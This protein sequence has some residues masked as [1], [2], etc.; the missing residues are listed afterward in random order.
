MTDESTGAQPTSPHP[1]PVVGISCS[2]GGIRAASYALGGLQVLDDH[3]LLR[4]PNRARYLSAVSGGSYLVGGMTSIQRSRERLEHTGRPEDAAAALVAPYAPGS[5][6]VRR[7]RNRLGYLTHG[8][9]GLRPELWR[10]VFG[11]LINVV[12]LVTAVATLARPIGWLA[13]Y[14]FPQLRWACVNPTVAGDGQ[15][16]CSSTAVPTPGWTVWGAIALVGIAVAIGGWAALRR[17][18]GGPKP[19]Q[20]STLFLL[21]ALGWTAIVIAGPQILG[22]LHRTKVHELA[23]HDVAPAGAHA[24]WFP[25]GGV[26]ALLGALAATVAPVWRT[27]HPKR[28]TLSGDATSGPGAVARFFTRHRATLLN[29][30]AVLVGPVLVISLFVVFAARGAST[31]PFADGGGTGFEL[32]RWGWPLALLAVIAAFGDVNG[33]ALHSLYAE[34]LGDAFGTERVTAPEPRTPPTVPFSPPT[35][36]APASPDAVGEADVHVRARPLPLD[37][38]QPECFPEVLICGTANLSTYGVTPTDQKAASFLLSSA[39]VGGAATG[40]IDT[41]RYNAE[42]FPKAGKLSLIDAVSI[43]GAAVAPAMGKMTRGPLRFLL[44]LA[45]IRLGV[46]VPNPTKVQERVNYRWPYSRPGL[47][48]LA[49]EMV[50]SSP[51]DRRY[52]YV[53]D[54]GHF[55]NLGLVELL[56][57]RCDWIFTIDASGD[58]IDTFGTLGDALSIAEAE[59]GVTVDIDPAG[60]MA[61][62]P[63]EP[64]L[65]TAPCSRGVI[66]YPARPAGPDSPGE[67][68]KEA[69]LVVV[70]AGVPRDAPWPI[71]A[72]HRRF[73]RFPTDPTTDQLFPAPRFDAY[74]SLGRFAMRTA[75]KHWGPDLEVLQGPG[76]G[77]PTPLP[78]AS[79]RRAPPV[80]PPV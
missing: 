22:W 12:A 19:W 40:S 34:R 68:A 27:M 25:S 71:T 2:G 49:R 36:E 26:I 21:L 47:T 64:T 43:S 70:K 3:G 16:I 63:D 56:A 78:T 13:G 54:G 17:R 37:E 52:L 65:V 9:G 32:L 42:A 41:T 76:I 66:H 53:S 23:N 48:Y 72:Y 79:A 39:S 73:P 61:P 1:K 6:E 29:L 11:I 55:D 33:W 35:Y 5:P 10:V 14:A 28:S 8:P 46:W 80:M 50:G 57:R 24:V 69:T 77:P 7:L 58:A 20:Y 31:P 51:G 59:L 15:S 4:G 67:P 74:V 60:D 44:A 30:V 75:L 62:T 38:A 45:N 18:G